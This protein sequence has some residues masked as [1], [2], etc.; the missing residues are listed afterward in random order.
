[1]S[2]VMAALDDH[3]LHGKACGHHGYAGK[4]DKN[5]REN[6]SVEYGDAIP[7]GNI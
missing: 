7:E 5:K 3:P 2:D 6:D 4:K 1:M